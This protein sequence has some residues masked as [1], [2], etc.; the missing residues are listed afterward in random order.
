MVTL[1]YFHIFF[2]PK[3]LAPSR[4]I[5]PSRPAHFHFP[6]KVRPRADLCGGD[7]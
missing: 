7:N 5:R 2:F 6:V 3:T 4:S 1:E